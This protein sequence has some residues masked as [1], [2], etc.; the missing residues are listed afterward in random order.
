MKILVVTNMYPHEK[1]P[2]Y[3]T[4]VKEQVISLKKAGASVD[5]YFINGKESRLKYFS[6]LLDLYKLYDKY[7]VIHAHHT[8]CIFPL[9]VIRFIKK[10]KVPLVLTFHE[11][12]VHKKGKQQRWKNG[13]IKSIVF[14]KKIK[15]AAMKAVDLVITV[16]HEIVSEAG[17]D[18]RCVVLPCGVDLE[19]FTP[20]DRHSC[21]ERLKLPKNKKIIFFPAAPKNTQ[22]GYDMLCAA[23]DRVGDKDIHLVAAGAIPYEEMPI[24]MGA[25]DVVVQLSDFE[26]SPSILK[27]AMAMNV[28]VVFTDVGDAKSTIGDAFGCFICNK[29]TE[30]VAMK[31]KEALAC[32]GISNGRKQIMKL[33]LGLT[34]V[35]K[36]I[37]GYYRELLGNCRESAVVDVVK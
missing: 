29:T 24:Y 7:D 15:K 19:T 16:Q 13:P 32:N 25:A 20:M 34:T 12:E 1:M 37:I 4:F 6:S 23:I 9:A 27:E 30:D 14:S 8:Y 31:L 35:A 3:G 21:R 2:F 26:A 36:K 22:K 5:V 28:P 18:G 33:G 11:G 17:F 10:N